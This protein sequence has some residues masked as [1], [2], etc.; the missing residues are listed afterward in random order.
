MQFPD[1][2][3]ELASSQNTVRLFKKFPLFWYITRNSITKLTICVTLYIFTIL[4][5]TSRTKKT[6]EGKRH[7]ISSK[8]CRFRISR[9][10]SGEVHGRACPWPKH[11]LNFSSLALPPAAVH[12]KETVFLQ[13]GP[14]NRSPG[15]ID[16]NSPLDSM[17]NFCR[18][19]RNIHFLESSTKCFHIP[20]SHWISERQDDV[21]QTTIQ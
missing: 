11:A 17:R 14:Y 8:K 16:L 13:N 19:L 20:F 10:S 21:A 9:K 18:M 6:E 3:F 15:K 2:I 1:F 4:G 7:K 5:A 12:C